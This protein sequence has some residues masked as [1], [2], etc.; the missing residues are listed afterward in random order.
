MSKKRNSKTASRNLHR[1]KSYV[2]N[3]KRPAV[4]GFVLVVVVLLLMSGIA[5]TVVL[6]SNSGDSV[7]PQTNETNDETQDSAE[8]KEN[9]DDSITIIA[10]SGKTVSQQDSINVFPTPVGYETNILV[11]PAEPVNDSIDLTNITIDVNGHTLH[12]PTKGES[13]AFLIQS[14]AGA[15]N[16]ELD[17]KFDRA[18]L[19]IP[20]GI[21]YNGT[22]ITDTNALPDGVSRYEPLDIQTAKGE[23]DYKFDNQVIQ[24][25]NV[26][27]TNGEDSLDIHIKGKHIKDKSVTLQTTERVGYDD[28]FNYKIKE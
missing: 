15:E 20:H 22:Q 17:D 3:K 23:Y 14:V 21:K 27:I 28:D 2:S 8:T 10:Q 7:P 13:P 24:L 19:V 4:V 6:N 1:F 25:L 11:K 5:G 16:Y 26:P 18:T 9:P 12:H